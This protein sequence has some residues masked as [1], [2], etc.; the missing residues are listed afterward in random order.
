MDVSRAPLRRGSPA[1]S[2]DG[3]HIHPVRLVTITERIHIWRKDASVLRDYGDARAADLLE[4]VAAE[5]EADLHDGAAEVTDLPSAV[6]LT[7][8]TRG[9]LRRLLTDG[10]LRNV[11]TPDEPAF[12]VSDLPR[13][14]GPRFAQTRLA[15]RPA[16]SPSSRMQVARAV[17]SRG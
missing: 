17:A 14:P 2:I 6:S 10:K 13:K 16:V 12:L 4:R 1:R 9:H 3:C 7:G 5:L 8:Y 15:P 11:G